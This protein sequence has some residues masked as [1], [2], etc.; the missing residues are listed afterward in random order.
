MSVNA[1]KGF[2]GRI[3]GTASFESLFTGGCIEIRSGAQPAN[4]DMAPTGVLLGRITH[5]GLVWTEGSPTNGLNFMRNGHRITNHPAQP[6]VLDG[7][8]NGVAGWMRLRG[9]NDPGTLS[10]SAPRIDGAV[11]PL[12]VLGDFQLLL[13]TTT[14]S[15]SSAI[16][17]TSWWFVFPPLD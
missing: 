17:I 6:W 11:G 15:A 14:I 4:A 9:V 1:S 13:P 5:N 8:A 12:D 3:L 16:P 2:R 10:T 7:L